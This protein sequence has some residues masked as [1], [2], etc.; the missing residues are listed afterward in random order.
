MSDNN[1]EKKLVAVSERV[2]ALGVVLA[3]LERT[4]EKADGFIANNS[5]S[6]EAYKNNPYCPDF[7]IASL[8]SNFTFSLNLWFDPIRLSEYAAQAGRQD[9]GS[10]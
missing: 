1:G 9:R 10:E 6:Y 7:P 2:A 3:E 4:L 5:F 8:D